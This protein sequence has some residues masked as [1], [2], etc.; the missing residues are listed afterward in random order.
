MGQV[1]YKPPL[2]T[3]VL[4]MVGMKMGAVSPYTIAELSEVSVDR[5]TAFITILVAN[6]IVFHSEEGVVP[7][8]RWEEWASKPTRARPRQTLNES[9]KKIDEIKVN[10]SKNI[11]KELKNNDITPY[12]LCK[13]I[14]I[15]REYVYT[16]LK[17]GSIPPACHLILIARGL[18]V[19]IEDLAR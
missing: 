10:I 4:E 12:Q 13:K 2:R 19:S 17:Y 6:K 11:E 5:A 18:G 3:T 7:G 1:N 9:I 15:K 16:L 8:P 14:G